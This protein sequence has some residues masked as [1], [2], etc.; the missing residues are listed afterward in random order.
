M[1]LRTSQLCQ[2]GI[3]RDILHRIYF[4]EPWV[5][6]QTEPSNPENGVEDVDHV[7]W[8]IC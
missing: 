3:R 8:T 5:F 7:S 1:Q 6:E 4:F 2:E